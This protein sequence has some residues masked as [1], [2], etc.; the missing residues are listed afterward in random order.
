[1]NPEFAALQVPS[2]ISPRDRNYVVNPNHPLMPE[3]FN[4]AE[5]LDFSFDQRIFK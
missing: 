3:I 2:T 5:K 1:E 4:K